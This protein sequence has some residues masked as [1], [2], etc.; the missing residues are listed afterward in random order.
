MTLLSTHSPVTAVGR[1]GRRGA[2]IAIC[3]GAFAFV[4]SIAGCSAAK[5]LTARMAISLAADKT[6]SVTSMAATFSDQISGTVAETTSGTLE[7]QIKPTLIADANATASAD[8][9]TF[10]IDEI[11]STRAMYLKSTV[12][13]VFTGQ[14]GKPWI[15]IPFASLSGNLGASLTGLLQNVQNGD[16]L[17][18]T[19][20]L[21]ASKNVRAVGS[22]VIN[23]VRTTHY[24]GSFTASAALASLSPALRREVAPLLKMVSGDIQ[25]NAWIDAQHVVRRVTEVETAGGET[26]HSTINVTS[27]NRPVRVALPSASEAV[28]LTKS[29]LG[30]M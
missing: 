6:Q 9:Q 29:D 18:Q 8:G 12:F 4:A 22:Q 21:A 26:V 15:E 30:G 20:M 10:P 2:A 27:V 24:R 17:T 14:T 19:K 3:A 16:P 1:R 5:P 28:V 11:V 25:F 7:M 13:S 23:G